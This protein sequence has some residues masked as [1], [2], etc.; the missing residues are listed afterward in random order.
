MIAYYTRYYVGGPANACAANSLNLGSL[1]GAV[2]GGAAG[3]A[4]MAAMYGGTPEQIL[5]GAAIGAVTGWAFNAVGGKWPSG[6]SNVVAHAAVGCASTMASGGSCRSGAIAAAAGSALSAYKITSGLPFEANLIAHAAAGGIG[7]ELGGGKF[8]NGAVMAS[9]GYLFNCRAHGCQDI[10]K[11]LASSFSNEH[12]SETFKFFYPSDTNP[13]DVNQ[14]DAAGKTLAAD[15]VVD[16]YEIQTVGNM[17]SPLQAPTPY[18]LRAFI[19]RV[20]DS[21]MGYFKPSLQFSSDPSVYAGQLRSSFGMA[22]RNG[23]A[24]TVY[25]ST[26]YQE[27]KLGQ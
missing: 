6:T 5:K 3:G 13:L 2:A 27:L 22:A 26:R 18:S 14:I 12:A 19:G 9:F 11:R 4:S 1:A 20:A 8:T 16:A 23:A 10:S 7:S 25:N 24:S 17:V 15:L 21:M